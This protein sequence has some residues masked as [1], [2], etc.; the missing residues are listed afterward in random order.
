MN[1]KRAD[2]HQHHRFNGEPSIE[3]VPH[4]ETR[5]QHIAHWISQAGSPPVMGLLASVLLLTRLSAPHL[6]TWASLYVLLALIAPMGFLIWQLR[7]GRVT[8]LDVHFRQQRTASFLVTCCGFLLVWIAMTLGQAPL[9]LRLLAGMGFLQ[10][11]TLCLITLKWKISVHATSVTGTTLI[12]VW[13]L[14]LAATPAVIAVPLVAWS[15]VKL[16]RHTPTQV[17]AGILL[18]C[19]VF[20]VALLLTPSLHGP[21]SFA[22]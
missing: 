7:R 5:G 1:D 20:T 22:P 8:D 19:A 6:W 4:P 12:L 18:G 14:G 9:L 2:R 13:S 10:W 15:R 16:R 11:V 3:A 21:G 17:L